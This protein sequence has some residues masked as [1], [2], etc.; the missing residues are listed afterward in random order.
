[1]SDDQP[2][3]T[4]RIGFRLSIGVRVCLLLGA[5]LLVLAGYLFWSPLGKDSPNGLSVRCGSAESPPSD[6]L[7]RA[8]CGSLNSS[9]RGAA[10]AALLAAVVV[11]GGGALAF[12]VTQ[13]P[14][15]P[16]ADETPELRRSEL[17]DEPGRGQG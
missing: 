13:R 12:G 11:S 8:A 6:A 7:R 3:A 1:M 17:E 15:L 14:E 16:P 5:L 4:I 9:R 2:A 10:L